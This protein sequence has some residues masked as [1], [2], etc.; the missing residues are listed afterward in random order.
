M[1]QID[2]AVVVVGAGPVGLT[3]AHQLAQSGIETIVLEKSGEIIRMPRAVGIDGESIRTWQA[4]GLAEELLPHIHYSLGGHYFNVEGTEMFRTGY[5]DTEQPCGYPMTQSFDQGETDLILAE[6][7]SKKDKAKLLFNHEVTDYNQTADGVDIA[8]LD[9]QGEKLSIKAKCLVGCDGGRSTI[10]RLLDVEM[11]G[12]TN[13][14]PW[15]V[16]DTYDKDFK[17]EYSSMFFCDPARP[18]MTIRVTPE[19][20]RWEW[21][22]LP[23]ENPEDFLTEDKVHELLSPFLDVTKIEIFR[24]RVYNFSAVIAEHWGDRR[25]ILAGDAAHMTPPFA[26]Q[27]LNAGIRDTRN[28]FW[29][30]AL[31]VKGVSA[32]DLLDT[33]E[34]ERREHTRQT[35]EFAVKLGEKI[36]P[37]DPELARERDEFFAR[38]NQNP[39]QMQE[40]LDEL[41]K[42]RRVREIDSGAVVSQKK[43]PINGRYVLQP[44]VEIPGQPSALLDHFLGSGF[45]LLGYDCDPKNILSA[46]MMELMTNLDTTF[47]Q[48]AAGTVQVIDDLFEGAKGTVALL[49]PD[50]F[51]LSAFSSDEEEQ[52]NAVADIKL[53]L[54]MVD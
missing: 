23:G 49:R 9:S 4:A 13:E 11:V 1:N 8:V 40:F 54:A 28:L 44:Q 41:R 6:A 20:R 42:S 14:W 32:V 21:Q 2:C 3:L 15:L 25:V 43:H 17:S 26:G 46:E 47:F 12:Q 35:I 31:V 24:Q 51:V 10:R 45:T 5:D 38:L 50:R 16:I 27:G 33:Y 36:Q 52:A 30:I 53:A 19:H 37:I 29:K 18:G 39:D 48:L 7:L 34:L 22:L